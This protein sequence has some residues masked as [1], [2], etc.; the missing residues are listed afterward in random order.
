MQEIHEFTSS[1]VRQGYASLTI[2]AY[3][4]VIEQ[5]SAWLQ[6]STGQP[7]ALSAMDAETVLAYRQHLFDARKK[8]NTINQA[9]AALS[10]WFKWAVANGLMTEN[11]AQGLTN[12]AQ[13][14]A[15]PKYLDRKEQAALLRA[16]EKDLQVAQAR[17]PKRFLVRRRD[18]SLTL[19]LLHTGLR[20]Q[21]VCDLRLD[22][23]PVSER[24]GSVLVRQGKGSK[25]RSIPLNAEA[26]KALLEW[27][28]LRPQDAPHDFVWVAIESKALSP[29]APRSVQR[30]VLRLG[31]D[32][33]LDDLTPHTLRHTFAKNL[34]NADV[35]LEK[36]AALLGHSN[37]NTTRIYITPSTKDLVDAVENLSERK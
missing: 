4:H 19:F 8:A 13:V 26:R 32:A 25:Q 31:Q 5:F 30:I 12:V 17:F 22:D 11:P 6:K 10:A 34:V 16:I 20:L 37:L 21:E 7:A 36:V 35:S 9:M 23:V 2:N 15:G 18:A 33:G 24:K 14:A 28:T 29:I 1:L 3:R 27:L